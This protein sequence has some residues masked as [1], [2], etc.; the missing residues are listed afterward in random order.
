MPLKIFSKVFKKKPKQKKNISSSKS[1]IFL[2]E[3]I[4]TIRFSKVNGKNVEIGK[5]LFGKIYIGSMTLPDGKRKKVAIKCYHQNYKITD[6]DIKKYQEVINKVGVLKLESGETI[7]PK[8]FMTKMEIDGK[9]EW[10]Q[11]SQLFGSVKKGSKFL[12]NNKFNKFNLKNISDYIE[13]EMKLFEKGINNS[14]DKLAY[15]KN[16]NYLVVL[17]IDFMHFSNSRKENAVFFFKNI[18]FLSKNINV[19]NKYDYL[20]QHYKYS[21]KFLSPK[22]RRYLDKHKDN[23]FKK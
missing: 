1:K 9:K 13:I 6:Y 16:N 15:F 18:E 21:R 20:K 4:K 17:D 12:P 19:D 22:N 7:F 11:I 23:P 8:M 2:P 3:E 10:V 5:G 14:I